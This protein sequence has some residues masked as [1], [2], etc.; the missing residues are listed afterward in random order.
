MDQ[1]MF[2]DTERSQNE[3]ASDSMVSESRTRLSEPQ[4]DNHTRAGRAK[5]DDTQAKPNKSPQS[6]AQHRHTKSM[7]KSM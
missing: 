4:K 6:R 7:H 1:D 2:G 5:M 3:P